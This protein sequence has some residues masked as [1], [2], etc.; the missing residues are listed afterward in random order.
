M[1]SSIISLIPHCV[2][3][4]RSPTPLF[5]HTTYTIIVNGKLGKERINSIFDALGNVEACIA[6]FM[7]KPDLK[8]SPPMMNS[9]LERYLPSRESLL[10]VNLNTLREPILEKVITIIGYDKSV[11]YQTFLVSKRLTHLINNPINPINEYRLAMSSVNNKEFVF[12]WNLSSESVKK[13]ISLAIPLTI[14]LLSSNNIKSLIHPYYD[15]GILLQ[16]SAGEKVTPTRPVIPSAYYYLCKYNIPGEMKPE[17]DNC[18]LQVAESSS[19]E[20]VDILVQIA[21]LLLQKELVFP[22]S[23]NKIVHQVHANLLLTVNDY[24]DIAPVQ[25]TLDKCSIC[26]QLCDKFMVI[27]TNRKK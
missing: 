22:F 20:D 13:R 21:K 1:L 23:H 16:L 27:D 4:D 17:V 26:Q 10:Q 5:S 14:A 12:L 9:I 18:L 8:F 25:F 15:D 2:P 24:V 6:L 7:Q 19:I 11:S 3:V